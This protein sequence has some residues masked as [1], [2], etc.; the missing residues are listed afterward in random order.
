MVQRIILMK[1]LRHLPPHHRLLAVADRIHLQIHQMMKKVV[2]FLF[3]TS[4]SAKV[5][6]LFVLGARKGTN[7]KNSLKEKKKNVVSIGDRA[8][9]I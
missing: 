9:G 4:L 5:T 8:T 1:A 6:K 2:L 3:G 7:N